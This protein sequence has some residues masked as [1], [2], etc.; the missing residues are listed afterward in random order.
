MTIILNSEKLYELKSERLISLSKKYQKN[1]LD[2]NF[3]INPNVG[4][5]LYNAKVH[6]IAKNYVVFSF[7]KKDYINLFILLKHINEYFIDLYKSSDFH[8]NKTIYD[9][10]VDKQD[11]FTIRCYLPHVKFKYFIKNYLNDEETYFTLPRKGVI[12]NEILIDIRNLWIKEKD[13]KVGFNLELKQTKIT[14]K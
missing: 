10:F 4:I 8:E 5:K 12:L 9:I 6:E 1:S 3:Y 11:F 13:N 14:Y 2:Y 7:D